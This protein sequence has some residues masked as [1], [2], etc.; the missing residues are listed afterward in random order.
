MSKW[1]GLFLVLMVSTLSAIEINIKFDDGNQITYTLP[2]IEQIKFSPTADSSLLFCIYFDH[3]DSL[4]VNLEAIK[5]ITFSEIEDVSIEDAA[6]LSTLLSISSLK[7]YPNP[8]NPTT[9]IVF[10]TAIQGKVKVEIFNS[11]GQLVSV[12]MNKQLSVGDHS[13]IWNGTDDRGREVASGV[14]FYRVSVNE[15]A[16]TAKMLYLR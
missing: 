3:S 2:E 16:E 5:E 12:L 13:L 9:T 10:N 11:R 4:C 8:F 7:N 1:V 15:D 14:Y 6:K